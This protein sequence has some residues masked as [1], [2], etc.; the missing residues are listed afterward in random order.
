MVDGG[1]IMH[2]PKELN[3]TNYRVD[4]KETLAVAEWLVSQCPPVPGAD[5]KP[6]VVPNHQGT[7]YP[8]A[9]LGDPDAPVAMI[10]VFFWK[11]GQPVF[12][13][14]FCAPWTNGQKSTG[15]RLGGNVSGA[16]DPLSVLQQSWKILSE[17]R[18]DLIDLVDEAELLGINGVGVEVQDA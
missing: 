8:E 7:Y 17:R 6:A 9:H 16:A 11:G 12:G 18:D 10:G 15:F 13:G 4:P 5:W 2:I 14:G 3:L 1:L